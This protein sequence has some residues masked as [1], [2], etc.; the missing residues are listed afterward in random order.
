MWPCVLH[1]APAGT[2]QKQKKLSPTPL[3]RVLIRHPKIADQKE[4]HCMFAGTSGIVSNPGT[5]HAMVQIAGGKHIYALFSMQA[6]SFN[7]SMH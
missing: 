3:P 5:P 7:T 4:Y 1:P 2:A 6:F